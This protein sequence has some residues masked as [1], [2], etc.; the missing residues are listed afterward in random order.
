MC[1]PMEISRGR[2]PGLVHEMKV[3]REFKTPRYSDLVISERVTSVSPLEWE[4]MY[5]FVSFIVVS[6][7]YSRFLTALPRYSKSEILFPCL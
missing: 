6:I 2:V 5:L 7:R 3:K 1:F 4:N